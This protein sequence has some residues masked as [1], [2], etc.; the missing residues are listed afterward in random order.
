MA[1]TMVPISQ[2]SSDGTYIGGS[3]NYTNLADATDGNAW[4]GANNATRTVEC[5]LT[6][7]SGSTPGSGTCTV[8]AR[9]AQCDSDTSPFIASSGGSNASFDLLVLEGTTTVASATGVATSDGSWANYT[10]LTFAAS[11]VTDWSNV[12]L[13]FVSNG[14]GGTP[15]GRRCAGVTYLE[16]SAPD[17]TT[18]TQKSLAYSGTG[19]SA[20]AK[21]ANRV[22]SLAYSGTGT[23]SLASLKSFLRSLSYSGTGTNALSRVASFLRSYSYSGTGTSALSKLKSL[24]RS[25]SYSGTG[26]SVLSTTR[27]ALKSFAYSVTGTLQLSRVVSWLKS[28]D[29]SGAG[30]LALTKTISFLKSLSY[31]ATGTSGNFERAVSRLRSFDYSATG[32]NVMAQ[33]LVFLQNFSYGASA[34]VALAR[35]L[36]KNLAYAV[37][38]TVT[39]IRDTFKAFSYS[40]SGTPTL[41][42]GAVFAV[43]ANINGAAT[44]LVSTLYTP[45]GGGEPPVAGDPWFQGKTVYPLGSVAGLTEW[46]DYIPVMASST[47]PGRYDNDGAFP[48]VAVLSSTAGKTAW[49]DYIPVY[50]V[51][52]TKPWSTDADGYIPFE[53]VTP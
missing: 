10:S 4:Y 44:A 31:G 12:R 38:G 8:T 27:V 26:T 53:D 51:V 22:R 7:L 9:Q 47:N 39:K 17:G 52:R 46:V 35:Q 30:T 49:A 34:S 41:A 14:T 50:V 13:R 48:T 42:Q 6:D 1:Q 33:T 19:T 37:T 23:A 21:V 3:T 2:I 16:I 5:L 43:I 25:L 36:G 20:L 11:S 40:G 18:T 28:L 29:Y 24:T 45:G 15:S 32:T